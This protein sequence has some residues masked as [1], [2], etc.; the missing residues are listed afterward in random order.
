MAHCFLHN[1]QVGSALHHND[2]FYA[3]WS[4]RT[5]EFGEKEAMRYRVLWPHMEV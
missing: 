5:F 3:S 4:N 2:P 1:P